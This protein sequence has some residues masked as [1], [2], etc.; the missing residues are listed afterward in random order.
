MR[1]FMIFPAA[2]L[3]LAGQVAFAAVTPPTFKHLMT[4]TIVTN[5]LDPRAY[6][7]SPYGRR[8]VGATYI[9]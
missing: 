3:A 8:L 2:V 9:G 4:G 5:A 7:Q 6:I 1:S